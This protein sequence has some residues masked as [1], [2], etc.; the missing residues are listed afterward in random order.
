M[1]FVTKSSSNPASVCDKNHRMPIRFSLQWNQGIG[2][3]SKKG[4]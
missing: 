1:G 2:K 3:F 4:G